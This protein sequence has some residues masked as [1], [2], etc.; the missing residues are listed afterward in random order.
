MDFQII[1][2]ICFILFVIY[3][4]YE[5]AELRSIVFKI[6]EHDPKE[7]LY[8]R[9][10]ALNKRIREVELWL[11]YLHPEIEQEKTKYNREKERSWLIQKETA[12]NWCKAKKMSSIEAEEY[13]KNYEKNWR[14]DYDRQYMQSNKETEDD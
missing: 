9:N 13:M 3:A 11:Q 1:I 4:V 8:Q 6:I 12:K 7:P 10:N 5:L 14:K 2:N